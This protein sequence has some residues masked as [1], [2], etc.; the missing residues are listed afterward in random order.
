[1]MFINRNYLKMSLLLKVIVFVIFCT[2][3]LLLTFG[4]NKNEKSIDVIPKTRENQIKYITDKQKT[5]KTEKNTKQK[6]NTSKNNSRTILKF[7]DSKR[8]EEVKQNDVQAAD[9]CVK[10]WLK[11]AN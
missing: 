6:T 8:Y 9:S 7:F 5:K 10:T 4:P 11:V 1:M 3:F 2:I